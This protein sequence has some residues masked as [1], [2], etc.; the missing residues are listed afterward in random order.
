MKVLSEAHRDATSEEDSSA[1]DVAPA[2]TLK[3]PVTL[4]QI[5]AEPSLRTMP[6]VRLEFSVMPV[7]KKEFDT[8]IAMGAG[9]V[10]V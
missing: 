3:N 4:S 5:E 6:L 8:I 9:T 7:D 2:W 10:K 1:V